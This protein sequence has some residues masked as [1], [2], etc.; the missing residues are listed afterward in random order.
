MKKSIAIAALLIAAG[1]FSF[2]DGNK[3]AAA[4]VAQVPAL[5]SDIAAHVDYSFWP[6]FRDRL[7]NRPPKPDHRP[8]PPGRYRHGNPPP[9]PGHY[10]HGNPPPPPSYHR[11]GG[12]PPP[13]RYKRQPPPPRR[14]PAPPPPRRPMPKPG[15]RR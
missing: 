8:P 14:K 13:P 10:R 6:R 12:P 11:S 9:P 3:A 15:P 5:Q 2:S 4:E 7:L 1:S